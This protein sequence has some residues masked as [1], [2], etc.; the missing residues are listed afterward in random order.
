MSAGIF[1]HK[2][3]DG[4]FGEDERIADLHA[5]QFAVLVPAVNRRNGDVQVVCE[6]LSPENLFRLLNGFL[7]VL[8]SAAEIPD[9]FRRKPILSEH[10]RDRND[11]RI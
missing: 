11:D 10:A 5:L 1:F 2:L 6:L 8:P 9:F 4:G 3:P 7:W